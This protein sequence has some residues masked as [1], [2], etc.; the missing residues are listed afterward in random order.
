MKNKFESSQT[1]IL[2]EDF[3]NVDLSRFEDFGVVGNFPYNI[4]SQIV[5]R[6][7]EY[8]HRV[9]EMV[10]MFQ[11]EVAMRIVSKPG[12]KTYGILSV[13]TDA[14]YER[15]VVLQLKPGAFHPPPKVDSTVIRLV[16]KRLEI[17]EIDNNLF[18][19]VVKASF[20]Q[21]RKTLK[22]SLKSF[23]GNAMFNENDQ[24]ILRRR[25]EE[26]GSEEFIY[27]TGRIEEDWQ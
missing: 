9:H 7:L 11:K 12:S 4:S 20:G 27:L 25:P 22:N 15:K 3:L 16:R 8:R 10:G 17:P 18:F 2:N 19:K 21:R 24:G 23:L 1:E 26:L 13:L 6:I 14:Y 5:F